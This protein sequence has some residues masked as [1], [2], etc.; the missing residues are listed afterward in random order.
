MS[1]QSFECQIARGQ[2]SRYLGGD[3]FSPEALVQLEAHVSGCPACKLHLGERKSALQSMLG[4]PSTPA[5]TER[6]PAPE[7]VV[8]VSQV[9]PPSP[10]SPKERTGILALLGLVG[11]KIVPKPQSVPAPA[12]VGTSPQPPA[13]KPIAYSVALAMVLGAMS[14]ASR[15]MDRI[16]GPKA[17]NTVAAKEPESVPKKLAAKKAPLKRIKPI[18]DDQDDAAKAA[19]AARNSMLAR[20]AK[21]K[22]GGTVQHAAQPLRKKIQDDPYGA[23][24]APKLSLPGKQPVKKKPAKTRTASKTVRKIAIPAKFSNPGTKRVA[25]IAKRASLLQVEAHVQ[26]RARPHV[27][28]RAKQHVHQKRKPV[29]KTN[30]LHVYAP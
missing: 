20:K 18:L 10:Q 4:Q 23:E 7:E 15:N 11:L 14:L 1:T 24:T 9:S 25:K 30:A 6:A 22:P 8:R 3:S 28:R 16:L 26:H 29:A 17:A 13:W 21:S 5:E 27:V 2:I 12:T 19:R